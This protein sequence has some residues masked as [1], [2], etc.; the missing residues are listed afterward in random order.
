MKKSASTELARLIQQFFEEYLPA[1]RGMS[2]HTIRS[3]RDAVVLF[4]HF[5]ARHTR[6]RIERL[7]LI[8]LTSNRIEKF[9]LAL[10]TER[11]NSI[12]TRNTR[13]AALHTL[14]RFLASQRPQSLAQWQTILGIPF[15]RGA[16]E[17]PIDYFERHELNA[18]F[19]SID[20]KSR[21][22]VRDYALFALMFNTGARVQEML[23]LNIQ[24][25]RLEPPYQVRLRGKGNK[26]RLCPL[27]P[28]TV[29]CLKAHIEQQSSNQSAT[30]TG[31]LF[32]NRN[33]GPLTRFGVRYL[34]RKYVAAVGA[35]GVS[36]IRNKRLHPHSIRHGTAIALLKSGVDFATTSQWLGH[37]TLNVTMRYARSDLDLKRAALSQVFPDAIAPPKAGH[38][39]IDGAELT[40]W[41]RR[42]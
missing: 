37:S 17:A 2:T 13:L 4:L 14:A 9:L 7:E 1:L 38:L 26:L 34:L 12:T 40:N 32:S 35:K 23:N 41:L 36:T 10:E 16:R 20:R 8:E 42:L 30:H 25:L 28:S 19:K 18:L 21:G 31:R 15:K 29:K 11:H 39:R 5:L 24:D 22:G 3:Y 33:G 27:W 6:Q